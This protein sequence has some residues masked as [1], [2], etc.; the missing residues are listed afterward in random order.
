VEDVQAYIEALEGVGLRAGTIQ[1]RVTGLKKFYEHCQENGIDV[2]CEAGFNPVAKARRPKVI[3]Y[4]MFIAY[5]GVWFGGAKHDTQ[6]QTRL[7]GD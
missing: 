4:G 5:H 2:Q 1:K 3:R 7:V 6:E